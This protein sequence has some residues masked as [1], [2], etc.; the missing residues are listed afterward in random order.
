MHPQLEEVIREFA[1]AEQRLR[2]LAA[3]VPAGWW[4]RRADPARWSMAECVTHLNLTAAAFLPRIRAATAEARAIG[5]PAPA[6]FRRDPVGWLLWRTAGPP[7]R[8]RV[9]TTTAFI[10]EALTSEAG[11]LE[12]FAARQTEQV[13]AVRQADGLPLHRVRVTSPFNARLRYSLFSCLTILPPHQHRHLWQA[14]QVLE[15]LRNAG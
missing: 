10:P 2:R 3:A 1:G 5:G 4:A 8:L 15:Q 9:R 13:E 12:T 14:E 7:V 11:L 6:R